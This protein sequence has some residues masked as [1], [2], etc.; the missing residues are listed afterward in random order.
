MLEIIDIPQMWEQ[1]THDAD[2]RIG[3]SVTL[4]P[5]LNRY[6]M[7]H[8]IL[9]MASVFGQRQSFLCRVIFHFKLNMIIWRQ[10]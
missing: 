2:N 10:K 8:H 4:I 3:A 6:A 7:I 9:N 1:I 5:V